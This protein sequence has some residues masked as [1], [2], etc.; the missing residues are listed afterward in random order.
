MIAQR[1]LGKTPVVAY[2]PGLEAGGSNSPVRMREESPSV[3]HH[4]AGCAGAGRPTVSL[5]RKTPEGLNCCG[6]YWTM[7]LRN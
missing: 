3:G 5:W 7:K 1:A 6:I 4:G 2:L